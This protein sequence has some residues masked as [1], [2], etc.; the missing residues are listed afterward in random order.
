MNDEIKTFIISIIFSVGTGIIS[1]AVLSLSKKLKYAM[2]YLNAIGDGVKMTL[3]D[4]IYQAY[5]YHIKNGYCDFSDLTHIDNL[6]KQYQ[7]LG[8][9]GSITKLIDDIHSLPSIKD[10]QI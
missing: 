2:E 1:G 7:A 10:K 9:N 4:R 8:G 5:K 6:Y 3:R